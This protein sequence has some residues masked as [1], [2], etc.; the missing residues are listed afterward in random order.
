MGRLPRGRQEGRGVCSH[1]EEGW[2]AHSLQLMFF[3]L[4]SALSQPQPFSL[5]GPRLAGPPALPSQPPISRQSVPMASPGLP[6]I[7]SAIFTPASVPS[8]H[9]VQLPASCPL[10]TPGHPP[11]AFSPTPFNCPTGM[12]YPQGGPGA[13]STKPL[14]AASIPP[15]PTGEYFPAQ[16][17]KGCL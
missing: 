9:P 10:P 1:S 12:G 17:L 6:P 3:V 13:P 5:P 7:G 14:A 4:V 2:D 16:S 11:A 8:Q 15:P